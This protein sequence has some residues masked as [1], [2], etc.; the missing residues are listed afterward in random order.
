MLFNL[1]LCNPGAF[2]HFFYLSHE[3]SFFLSD[4]SKTGI[5]CL[6]IMTETILPQMLFMSISLLFGSN[7]Y[8]F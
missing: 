7:F 2:K 3:V 4:D 6:Y 5:F 8:T 1:I